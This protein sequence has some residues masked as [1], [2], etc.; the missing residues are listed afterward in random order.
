MSSVLID[1]RML[2]MMCLAASVFCSFG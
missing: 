2:L 1:L